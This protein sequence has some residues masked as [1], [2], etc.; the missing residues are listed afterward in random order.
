VLKSAHEFHGDGQRQCGIVSAATHGATSVTTF[1][2]AKVA[3]RSNTI[4]RGTRARVTATHG[5]AIW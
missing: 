3:S 5:S 2:V 1:E 4:V